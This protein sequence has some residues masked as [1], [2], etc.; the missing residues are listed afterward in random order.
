M[1]TGPGRLFTE[2][3]VARHIHVDQN[4]S[5]ATFPRPSRSKRGCRGGEVDA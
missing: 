3:K 1:D 4:R 2:I 5:R